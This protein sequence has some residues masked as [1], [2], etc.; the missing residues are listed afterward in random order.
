MVCGIR[1]RRG[2]LWW[3]RIFVSEAPLL[4]PRISTSMCHTPIKLHSASY[5]IYYLTSCR[6]RKGIKALVSFVLHDLFLIRNNMISQDLCN[7]AKLL[8]TR[9]CISKIGNGLL[10]PMHVDI[11]QIDSDFIA[12]IC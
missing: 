5:F 11:L 6:T 12:F 3:N 10:F 9:K 4:S 7:N 8:R 2:C 1:S